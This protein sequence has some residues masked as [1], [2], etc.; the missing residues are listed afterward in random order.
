MDGF[1]EI[2]RRQEHK[3]FR[4]ALIVMKNKADAE[5]VLQDVFIK[6]VEKSPLFESEAHE[7]AWLMRVMV[8]L[9]KSRLRA[10]WRKKQVPLTED[11]PTRD[12][13]QREVTQAVL[14]LPT[15]LRIAV[16][17]YYYHGYSTREIAEITARKESTV[18]KDLTRARR[19]LKMYLE[20]DSHE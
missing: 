14:A 3:L 4:T 20:G 8:N 16:N 19:A 5:D 6:L 13:T 15:I 18:R 7:T 9:C 2:V 12:D 1:A 11:Y 10:H 17:L